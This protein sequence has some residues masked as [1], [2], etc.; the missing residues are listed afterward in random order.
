MLVLVISLDMTTKAKLIYVGH[1]NMM[2]MI[3]T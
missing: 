2:I 1:K 3:L